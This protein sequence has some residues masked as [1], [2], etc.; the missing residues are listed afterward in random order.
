MKVA[1]IIL[2]AA[3]ALTLYAANEFGKYA[4]DL[5]YWAKEEKEDKDV[6]GTQK[7]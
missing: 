2:I 1:V 7:K 4:E 6:S 5:N 3:A